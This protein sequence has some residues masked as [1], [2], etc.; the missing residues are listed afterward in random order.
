MLV[1]AINAIFLVGL[2]KYSFCHELIVRIGLSSVKATF[3]SNSLML[4]EHMPIQ[5]VLTVPCHVKKRALKR[6][7]RTKTNLTPAEK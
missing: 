6:D 7:R 4:Y 5:E 3:A 2:N 1:V